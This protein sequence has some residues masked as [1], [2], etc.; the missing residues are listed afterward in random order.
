M[1]NL[2]NT[3][4]GRLTL[5][6]GRTIRSIKF[7][8]VVVLLQMH[9][10]DASFTRMQP[11]LHA[12]E[13]NVN[14]P[15][16]VRDLIGVLSKPNK[17]NAEPLLHHN[18]GPVSLNIIVNTQSHQYNPENYQYNPPPAPPQMG[19]YSN[20]EPNFYTQPNVYYGPGYN[21]WYHNQPYNPPSYRLPYRNQPPVIYQ[22]SSVPS[23]IYPYNKPANVVDINI[24]TIMPTNPASKLPRIP[25]P[26]RPKPGT[27]ITPDSPL[28]VHIPDEPTTLDIDPRR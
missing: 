5:N 6:G 13:V 20:G 26:S 11:L 2:L 1:N 15:K 21:T 18:I 8:I 3:V 16:F 28:Y 7:V 17:H 22:H 9:V 23:Q 25:Y 10:S 4:S 12:T 27:I 14:V 19:Y 24:G